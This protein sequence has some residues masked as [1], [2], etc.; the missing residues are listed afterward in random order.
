MEEAFAA[1]EAGRA[2][3]EIELEAMDAALTASISATLADANSSS[4]EDE[5]S[6]PNSGTLE[7][8]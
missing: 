3:R 2:Q 4:S 5:A 1:Y 6:L 8:W 7:D